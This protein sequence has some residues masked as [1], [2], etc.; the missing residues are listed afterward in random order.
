[1]I[2]FRRTLLV[3]AILNCKFI[4]ENHRNYLPGIQFVS[5]ADIADCVVAGTAAAAD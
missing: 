5:P 2:N 4:V 1:M 3:S